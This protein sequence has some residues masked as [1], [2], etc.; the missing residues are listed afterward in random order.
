ME[1]FFL[2]ISLVFLSTFVLLH[3]DPF[4]MEFVPVQDA[5]N[6]ADSI[7][8]LGAVAAPYQ[9]GKYEVTLAQ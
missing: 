4:P 2:P 6:V 8:K 3:A 9:I 1:R 7:T 5:G